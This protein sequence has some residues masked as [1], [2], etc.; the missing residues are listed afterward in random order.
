MGKWGGARWR[1]VRKEKG[2]IRAWAG[3]GVRSVYEKWKD[4]VT[5]EQWDLGPRER[6]VGRPVGSL[7]LSLLYNAILSTS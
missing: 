6:R 2:S 1:W 5:D 4:L 3:M 7:A